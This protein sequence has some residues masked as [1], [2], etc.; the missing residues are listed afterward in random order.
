MTLS[1]TFAL[2]HHWP[3][4]SGW[5]PPFA[6]FCSRFLPGWFCHRHL[7]ACCSAATG[8]VNRFI[9]NDSISMNQIE[10][11]LI[12]SGSPDEG[13]KHTLNYYYII[14]WKKDE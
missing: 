8:S 2:S 5:V 12:I 1:D 6:E 10:F 7:R 11:N 9:I 13:S 14:T 3:A 4:T